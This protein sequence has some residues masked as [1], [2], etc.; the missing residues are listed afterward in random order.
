VREIY[1]DQLARLA[2]PL[3][4]DALIQAAID[5]PDVEVR[6]RC[7][8]HVRQL[9]A[10]RA[11]G[12][13]TGFL[14]SRDNRTVNR[15]GVALGRLGRPEAVGPLIDALVTQHE[16]L[17]KPTAS[18]QPSFGSANDG[19][20]GLNGLSIGGGP[21]VVRRQLRNQ[22]V[23]DA[24]VALTSQNYRFSQADWKDWYIQQRSLPE[25]VNL[26]RD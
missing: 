3:A 2:T 22:S 4:L 20:G 26:R 1:A 6:L 12:A 5:D 25:D 14:Q 13:W 18:I 19:S 23:L 21:K 16:T 15:A 11:V 9:G 7:I 10:A 17:V 8:D 24:L